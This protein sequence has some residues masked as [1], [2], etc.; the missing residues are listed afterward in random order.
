MPNHVHAIVQ[1]ADG[2]DLSAILHT[3]KSYTAHEANKLLD[4][5]GEFWQSESYDHII[6]NGRAYHAAVRYVLSNP[7]SAGLDPAWPWRGPM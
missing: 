7:E 4:R 3:W 6:R 1:P 2:W 5:A